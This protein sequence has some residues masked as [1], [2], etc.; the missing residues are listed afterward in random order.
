M[1]LVSSHLPA[2]PPTAYSSG[3][4]PSKHNSIAEATRAR[5]QYEI[6]YFRNRIL[7]SA[8]KKGSQWRLPYIW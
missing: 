4:G 3:S 6:I 8:D 5:A 7:R 1:L 2:G